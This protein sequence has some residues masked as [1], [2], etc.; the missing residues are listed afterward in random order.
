MG[1]SYSYGF[2]A[3]SPGA[4]YPAPYPTTA[5]PYYAPQIAPEQEASVL[6]NQV[7]FM[8]ESIKAAQDRIVELEKEVEKHE[9]SR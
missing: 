4:A 3:G 7:E 2:P 1:G 5:P 9:D 6:K 8:Q